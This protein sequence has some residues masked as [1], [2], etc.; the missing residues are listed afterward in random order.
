M[1]E[2]IS[3]EFDDKLNVIGKMKMCQARPPFSNMSN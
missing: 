2:V 1:V 3:K